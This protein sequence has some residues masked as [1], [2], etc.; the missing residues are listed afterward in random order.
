MY[1][2]DLVTVAEAA[3]LVG[4]KTWTV[5]GWVQERRIA[6]YRIAGRRYISRADIAKL[7]TFAPAVTPFKHLKDDEVSAA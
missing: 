3:K 4:R 7:I 6:S 1:P 5:Y 2:D